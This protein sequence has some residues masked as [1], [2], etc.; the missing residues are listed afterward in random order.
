[1]NLILDKWS[2]ILEHIRKEHELSD[3]SFETWLL[4]LKIHSIEGHTVRII[5]PVDQMVTYLN[6]KF[7]IPIYV[8]IAEFT[9]EKYD[10]EFITKEEADAFDLKQKKESPATSALRRQVPVNVISE[11]SN[12]NAK[13]TFD[14]FVVGNNNKFA[15]AASLAVAETP[16]I[17][18][19]PLFLHGGVGLGKTHLM[20]AIAN[21]ILNIN[22]NMKVLYVTSEYFTNELIETLR[23][24]DPT[25][26]TKF[27]EKYRNIDVLL[28]DDVQFIIG[29]ESTQEEFFHTFN[30]LHNVN[31]QIIISSDRP[32]KDIETLEERLRTRFECGLIADISSPDFETRMAI[33]RKKEELE[34]YQIDDGIITY[35]ATNVKSNIRELEGAF[36][37]LIA[38]S[39]L[40]KRPIDMPLAEEAIKDIISPGESRKV[41]PE[42]IIDIV[43]EHFHVKPDDIK[44]KKRT[45]DIVYPRQIAMYL[46]QDH[47]T[48]F[49]RIGELL[50]G[51]DHTTVMH[52][53][54]KISNELKVNDST[55][56]LVETIRKKI[57]PN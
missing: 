33:L 10:I 49:K 25:G 54:E 11:Q 41:T 51:R 48:S 31:K 53:V 15:H 9:G 14:T 23:A 56:R 52:G 13:Y 28:I 35:I 1:M 6:S 30:S 43:A 8:A 46:C 21:H 27:R 57:Y 19:N 29:K 4:P 20:H 45:A 32:P 7:K 47:G 18:Y 24:G 3:V 39:T 36:N 44:G 17:V 5:V 12:I 40:E 38:L 50:G 2:D 26:M 42:L 55:V 34:G 22:P 37:R 16:G